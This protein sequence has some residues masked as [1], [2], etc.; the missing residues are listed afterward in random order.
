MVFPSLDYCVLYHF[1]WVKKLEFR[2]GVGVAQKGQSSFLSWQGEGRTTDDEGQRIAVRPARP[3]VSVYSVYSWFTSLRP[4][5]SLRRK[6]STYSTRLYLYCN[7]TW[8]LDTPAALYTPQSTRGS[9]GVSDPTTPPQNLRFV[10]R[11][12]LPQAFARG[13]YQILLARRWPRKD[14]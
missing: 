1:P 14:K 12:I 10:Q 6:P 3:T 11:H 5:R 4:L 8:F 9:P 2:V 7:T 13:R